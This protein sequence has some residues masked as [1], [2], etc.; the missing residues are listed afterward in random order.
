MIIKIISLTHCLD[1]IGCDT[2]RILYGIAVAGHL[3][4]E[5]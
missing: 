5:A 3:S 4:W 1:F 2:I